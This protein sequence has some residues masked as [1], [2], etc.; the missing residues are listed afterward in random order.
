MM[1]SPFRAAWFSAAF[2]STAVLAACSGSDTVGPPDGTACTVGSIAPGDSVNGNVRGSSCLAFNPSSYVISP[3][4]SWT[5]NAKKGTAYIIRLR[6][7]PNTAAN[8]TWAGS[9]QA[10]G[11]NAQG[12]ATFVTGRW[13]TFGTPNGNGG[14]NQEMFIAADR[15]RTLS[16]RVVSS[17][18]ADTGAYSLAI[19]SC[20]ITQISDTL[21][22][23]GIDLSNG[24]PSLSYDALPTKVTFVSYLADSIVQD[25]AIVTRTAGTGS[26]Q[27][28]LTGIGMDV[29][30]WNSDCVSTTSGWTTATTLVTT[31]ALPG[32][33]N[34]LAAVRADSAATVT[35]RIHSIPPTAPPAPAATARVVGPNHRSH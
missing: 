33:M 12:D 21:D 30:C 18:K 13:S 24:C 4:E 35:V 8:D 2:L 11:R 10:F 16:I 28:Y 17:T 6:H 34:L 31:P 25:S 32:T 22:H 26:F 14:N 1:R 5:L 15:D 7:Q 29:N 23:A 19:S 3:A 9:L 20:P 27:G